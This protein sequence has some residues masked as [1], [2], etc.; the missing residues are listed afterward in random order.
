MRSSNISSR[1]DAL[2]FTTIFAC[3][4]GLCACSNRSPAEASSGCEIALGG[5]F[6]ESDTLPAG[7]ATVAQS[8]TTPDH[9]TLTLKGSSTRLAEIFAYVDLG[10]SP[11]AGPYSSE[12]SATWT[13]IAQDSPDVDSGQLAAFYADGGSAACSYAA[14]SSAI[15]SGSFTLTLSSITTTGTPAAHGTLNAMMQVRAPPGAS[16]GPADFENLAFAF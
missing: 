11:A 15:P 14:G 3:V 16:C 6:S 2:L 4:F 1:S 5:D 7:C 9:W 13:V 12:T 10:P 8:A